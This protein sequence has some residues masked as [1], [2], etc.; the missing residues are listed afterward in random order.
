[1]C[2]TEATEVYINPNNQLNDRPSEQR[3]VLELLFSMG[4]HQ[5]IK[6]GK[7]ILKEGELADSIFYVVSG[8]FRAYR[9]K[10]EEEITLGF[11]FEGDIDTCPHAFV[12]QLPATDTIE[13]LVD[14]V[15]IKI[16]RA[17]LDQLILRNPSF[18]FFTQQL[19]ADYI[20][21]LLQRL[22]E[23]KTESAEVLYHKLYLRQPKEVAIIPLM[24]VASYLGISRERLSRI[25]KKI[26]P[27][28]LGQKC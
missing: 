5:H 4:K 3:K 26:K 11:S 16:H 6:K 8:C 10:N 23:L 17:E 27:V 7:C 21:N 2:Q 18:A 1:L 15:V 14:S 24:Y 20:E 22:I 13:A 28:D 25:R 19:L 12:H 9:W